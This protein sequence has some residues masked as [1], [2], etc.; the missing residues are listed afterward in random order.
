MKS[1]T[2]AACL[3]GHRFTF[4]CS[5]NAAFACTSEGLYRTKWSLPTQVKYWLE[6]GIGGHSVY[7]YLLRRRPNQGELATCRVE[8]GGKSA[9]KGMSALT[10]HGVFDTDLSCGR[11]HK[12]V[13]LCP[14]PASICPEPADVVMMNPV[15]STAQQMQ[16]LAAFVPYSCILHAVQADCYFR[17]DIPSTSPL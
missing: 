10:R 6:K 9:P 8:F 5:L 11:E 14:V 12:P 3:P 7:K 4:C 1:C 16:W 17:Q 15:E 2:V 13:S